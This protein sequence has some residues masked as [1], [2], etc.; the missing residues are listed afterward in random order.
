MTA[1]PNFADVNGTRLYYEAAGNGQPLVLIHGFGLDCRLWDAQFAPLARQYRVV[2]Y[3]LRGFGRSAP[4]AGEGYRHV[5]DL[6]ALLDFLHI[7]RAHLLGF[8]LGGAIALDF[9]LVYPQT[10]QT[11]VLVDSVLEGYRMS[12][13]WDESVKSI[14]AHGRAGDVAGA[15]ALWYE[16]PLFRPARENPEAALHLAQ[17]FQGYSGWHYAH[18]NPHLRL[19]PPAAQRLSQIAAPTLVVLGEQ[20]LPDFHAVAHTLAAEIPHAQLVVLPAAGHMCNLEA[21]QQFLQAVL[22]FLSDP[23]QNRQK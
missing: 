6:K 22:D 17:L 14:W 23:G 13:E 2:R 9:A 16:H 3:D 5:D 12:R 8:S 7:E 4:P 18:R 11:L 15:K 19:E 1:Q 21:P 20:D 10:V